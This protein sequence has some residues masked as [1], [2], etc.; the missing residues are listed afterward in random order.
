MVKL[1][2]IVFALAACAAGNQ[3][4]DVNTMLASHAAPPR[5]VAAPTKLDPT[6]AKVGQWA[7]YR[8]THKGEVGYERVQITSDGCGV[9][10]EMEWA[11]H[12]HHTISKVC[13]SKAP[14]LSQNTSTW[15]DLV[16]IVVSKDDDSEPY[17][18]D[19]RNGQNT[20][21]G[22]RLP[23]PNFHANLDTGR[24]RHPDLPRED[25]AVAAGHFA[26][27]VKTVNHQ[28]TV[29]G[30]FHPGV[31]IMGMVKTQTND[32]TVVEL[33]SYGDTGAVS[34]L[35]NVPRIWQAWK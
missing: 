30:W 8:T 18:M 15:A 11:T 17:V 14:D 34:A 19:L 32:G 7:L 10:V 12:D 21:V 1:G 20:R 16:Q 25:I 23:L 2:A 5:D 26:G 3:Q 22:A 29:T 9:W 4:T 33:V 24:W 13:Y 28:H 35:P 27:A 6:P 31:P